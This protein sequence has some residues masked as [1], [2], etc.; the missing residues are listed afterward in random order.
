[1]TM[2]PYEYGR[3]YWFVKTCTSDIYLNAGDVKVTPAGVLLFVRDLNGKKQILLA[4]AAGEWKYFFAAS[5]FN[6][7]A[8]SVDHWNAVGK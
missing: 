2:Q 7:G 3:Y 6:G 5:G 8:V 1:M 4:F